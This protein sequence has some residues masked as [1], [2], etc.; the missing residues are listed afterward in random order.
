MSSSQPPAGPSGPGRTRDLLGTFAG[1]VF[2]GAAEIV[3][4]VSGG[5]IA[6]VFGIYDRFIATLSTG[7][8][9]V[10]RAVRADLAGAVAR[11]RSLDWG[12]AIALVVGMGASILTLSGVLEHLLDTQPVIMSALFFGLVLGSVVLARRELKAPLTPRRVAVLAVVAVATFVLLGMTPGRVVDPS[13]PQFF[14]AAAIAICAMIL[15]GISGSFIL[16]LMGMYAPVISAVNGRDLAVLATFAVGAGTGLA[17]FSSL[18]NRV[19]VRHHDLTL[20]SLIGLMVGSLRVLWPWPA[21]AEGVGDARLAAP[22]AAELGPV[23]LAALVGIVVVAGIAWV[24]DRTVDLDEDDLRADDPDAD[25][26]RGDL[27]SRD[28]GSRHSR[29]GKAPTRARHDHE[30]HA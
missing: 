3:P 13:L 27:S 18:L 19:L 26:G 6:L 4:G 2:M 25:A 17:V 23:L 21:G 30:E 15:P 12:F 14:G 7:A 9:A 20:A 1:G 29:T 16:L 10:G 5:T 11:L 8:S 28:A 22:V 24:G